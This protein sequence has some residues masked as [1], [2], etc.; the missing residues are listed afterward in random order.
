MGVVKQIALLWLLLC[1]TRDPLLAQFSPGELSRAH[2]KLEGTN[3]CTQ[4][5]EVGD[6]ISGKKCLTCHTEIQQSL[7]HREGFHSAESSKQCIAC[8]KEHLGRDSHTY[9]FDA[10]RFDHT[11]TGFP[12][13][14]KHRQVTC[15]QCHTEKNIHNETVSKNL[16]EYPHTTY[17]GLKRTCNSCHDDPH[18][19]R[20]TTDC[21]SCHT[22]SGWKPASKFNHAQS[23]FK[24]EGK[25]RQVACA[26]CHPTL[27]AS[28][29]TL[30]EFM[31][32]SFSDCAPCHQT[33]HGPSFA[34]KKCKSCHTTDTWKSAMR[35]N[36]DHNLTA[37]PLLGKHSSVPCDKCHRPATK[38][39]T[40]KPLRIPFQQCTDCHKDNHN[41]EFASRD[42]N[43]CTNCH[44]EA[45]FSPSLY[46]ISDH[47][48]SRFQL[49]GAHRA[50]A[51]SFCHKKTTGQPLTFN[52]DKIDCESC[53]P[54]PHGKIFLNDG[55]VRMC[56]LCHSTERWDIVTFDH[57][58]TDF[59]LVG[60]HAE[61]VC[62]ACHRNIKQ[63]TETAKIASTCG[64]C[65]KDNHQGQF[66]SSQ[67]SRCEN[68][69][70]QIDWTKLTFNHETQSTFSLKG[71]HSNVPC[72]SCHYEEQNGNATFV[73]Y[74]PLSGTCESC[75]AK[76]G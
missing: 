1:F 57:S 22:V 55:R 49:T 43:K 17:L 16:R 2:T 32:K 18:K 21:S 28:K 60:K 3:N 54:N 26:R 64:S 76:K 11:Q 15:A 47:T 30:V 7:D 41:G 13:I 52:R 10:K 74:T 19:K 63:P 66:A 5:H 70:S 68:C 72:R 40:S 69:H 39:T 9:Q 56:E 4:C 31:T 46:T 6:V 67:Q 51:C 44:N 73:R 62:T 58:G 20:F 75:H 42:N 27:T 59:P 29:N 34:G 12:L 38:K 23:A 33:P 25:H 8:H 37:Y 48:T 71:A 14:E 35:K 24:L 53:H 36:F 61:A 65:H 45:G 50:T